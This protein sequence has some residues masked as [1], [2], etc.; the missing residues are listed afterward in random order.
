MDKI[1]DRFCKAHAQRSAEWMKAAQNWVFGKPGLAQSVS[2]YLIFVHSTE[3]NPEKY[4]LP[5]LTNVRTFGGFPVQGGGSAVGTYRGVEIWV[6][7]QF[8]GGTAAQLWMECLAGTPVRYLI[9]LA[10][11]TAYVDEVA[12]GD[13]VLPTVSAR[14][15]M[16]TDFHALPAVPA[17]ADFELLG[18]LDDKLRPTGWPVHI[19]PVYTGMPGGIGVHNP[20]LREKIW[21][22]LQAGLLGNAQETSVTYLEAMR[23]GIRAAEA[24][25]VSDDMDYGVMENAPDGRRRWE[26]AWTLMAQAGLDVLADIASEAGQPWASGQN[27]VRI[28]AVGGAMT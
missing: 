25:V 17:T 3:G 10:D 23:L 11:M 16:V 8:M 7:H 18:R 26:H 4:V 20:R 2:P 27:A 22:H 24:W 21:G 28:Q 12:V 13:L 19:G 1:E 9:G 15:E 6:L 14:G 5:L